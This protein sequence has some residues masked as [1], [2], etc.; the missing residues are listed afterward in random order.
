MIALQPS[1][2]DIWLV[3]LDPVKGREQAGKRPALVFSV[4]PF[5]HGPADLVVVIPITS[6]SKSIPFHVSVKPPEGGL[7]LES[8]IK[9]EDVRSISKHRLANRLGAITP[10]TMTAVEDRVRILLGL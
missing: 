7:K 8:F 6:K 5:N 4:D 1:R 2:G 9:C 3:D 10:R